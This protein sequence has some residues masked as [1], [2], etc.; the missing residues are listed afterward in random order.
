[1]REKFYIK[2]FGCQ[3]NEYDTSRI[4][5]FL[6]QNGYEQTNNILETNIFIF[7][8]CN[9]REKAA[10]KVY[11]EIGRLNHSLLKKKKY[12]KPIIAVVGCVGQAEGKEI[13]RRAPYVKI[14]TGPQSYHNLPKMILNAKKSDDSFINTDF[15]VENKF[16]SQNY[17]LNRDK[18]STYIT[19]QEGCDKFCKFC[20]VPYTRGSEF[21]RNCEEIYS[22]SIKLTENGTREIILLGQNVNAYLGKGSDNKNWPLSQLINYLSKIKKLKR[23]R[24]T[25]SHPNDMADDLINVHKDQEK[26][27]PNL[28]LPIQSGSDKVLRSM[29]R[30][31]SVAEY[32]NIISKIRKL[33]PDIC[34]SSDFIVGYPSET[35]RD[36]Q[37]SLDLVNEIQFGKAYSFK[38]SPRYGTPAAEQKQIPEEIKT[39]RLETLQNLL[40]KQQKS[41][42]RNMLGKY[43][44]VLFENTVRNGYL[45]GR[46]PQMQSVCV[47]GNKNLVGTI[48]K[49]L[50][51]ETGLNTLFGTLSKNENIF[52]IH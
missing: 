42:N 34:I 36:F 50:I 49:V 51:N 13:F 15:D 44:E 2:T 20:V 38:Y 40:T 6:N 41:Y 28:H 46:T 7:N 22:E 25:T 1:M 39:Y 26:L 14:V 21:S 16:Y 11:S 24:Y 12:K 33:K 29:N 4:V 17:K 47:Q 35:E 5:N 52:N 48:K 23:I 27:M 18:V 31:H 3:M 10:D 19:I 8:T 30:K 43:V 9:I 45:F 37:Q 32:K